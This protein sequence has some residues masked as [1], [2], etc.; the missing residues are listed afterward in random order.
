MAGAKFLNPLLKSVLCGVG[1]VVMGY[2]LYDAVQQGQAME[3][4]NILRGLVF[5]GF[6]YLLYRSLRDVLDNSRL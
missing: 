1:M 3:R 2:Y 4:L 6:S 5:L